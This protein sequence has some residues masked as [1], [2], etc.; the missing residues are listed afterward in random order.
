MSVVS[1]RWCGAALVALLGGGACSRPGEFTLLEVRPAEIRIDRREPLDVLARNL[2]DMPRVV[3]DDDSRA[4]L[5]RAWSAVVEQGE[6]VTPVVFE[7]ATSELG[8]LW[9]APGLPAGGYTLRVTA[10][11]GQT[12]ILVDAFTIGTVAGDPLD[13]GTAAGGDASVPGGTPSGMYGHTPAALY[14]IDPG[15]GQATPIGAFY[16]PAGG[17]PIAMGD[18]ASFGGKLYGVERSEPSALYEIDPTTATITRLG[19]LG[20]YTLWALA[21]VPAGAGAPAGLYASS[22]T[23]VYHI[24]PATAAVTELGTL[25]ASY[26]IVGD[27]VWHDQ[28]LLGA[29]NGGGCNQMNCIVSI[30]TSTGAASGARTTG[31]VGIGGLASHQGTL[32]AFGV[33]EIVTVEAGSG[34]T[35]PLSSQQVSWTGA[36][37]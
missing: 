21:G 10:P 27:L 13:A 9:L 24:D 29:V 7:R 19:P 1:I 18:I 34:A 11:S 3:L 6:L 16:D 2:H 31:I 17:Q 36:A 30:S 14:R 20:T 12:A 32:Y 25:G 23:V 22:A 26:Q 15:T 33:D 35:S 4:D 37:P 8:K 5:S 28:A